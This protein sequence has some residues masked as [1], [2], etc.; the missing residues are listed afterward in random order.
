MARHQTRIGC[1]R[2]GILTC[3]AALAVAGCSWIEDISTGQ[4]AHEPGELSGHVFGIDL[5]AGDCI[6]TELRTEEP[7]WFVELVPCDEP[8]RFEVA[9]LHLVGDG[10]Y[11]GDD[12]AFRTANRGCRTAFSN[13]VGIDY[14]SAELDYFFYW[15]DE[16]WWDADVRTAVCM[17]YDPDRLVTGT[18]RGAQR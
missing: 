2:A 14:R 6:L 7:M 15:P 16:S 17:V 1:F 3:L 13:F 18:L 5:V 11:P 4:A 9:E 8:H 12:Q 10:E